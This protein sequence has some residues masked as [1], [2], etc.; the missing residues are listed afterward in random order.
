MS[1]ISSDELR[2]RVEWA[3]NNGKASTEP[4]GH[5]RFEHEGK[6]YVI[7]AELLTNHGGAGGQVELS[8]YA[9]PR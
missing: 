6:V 5:I 9:V 7:P 4:G 1:A 8:A 2:T 3:R